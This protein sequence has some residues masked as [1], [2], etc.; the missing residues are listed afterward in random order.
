MATRQNRTESE[1]V[2]RGQLLDA[3]RKVFREKGYDGATVSEIAIEARLGKGTFYYYYPSKTAIAV[4][5]RDGLMNRMAEAVEAATRPASAF[6]PQ[7]TARGVDAVRE[8]DRANLPPRS[9]KDKLR[10]PKQQGRSPRVGPLFRPLLF[11]Q[12]TPAI[13]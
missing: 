6:A 12:G 1:E 2:R 7:Q 8:R 9:G 5:L 13:L 3:A 10:I 4:A 11:H